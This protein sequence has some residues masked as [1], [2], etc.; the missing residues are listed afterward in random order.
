VEPVYIKTIYLKISNVSR[1]RMWEIGVVTFM[2]DYL[3][4][5]T[6]EDLFVHNERM[7]GST[8]SAS[9]VHKVVNDNNNPYM[10]MVMDAMKMND[11]TILF[12]SFT[13]IYL[14]FYLCFIYKIP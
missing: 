5:Y 12:D 2:K 4:W 1:K 10:N 14:V 3:Y 8:S 13:H 6:H 11:T 9:N 7:V